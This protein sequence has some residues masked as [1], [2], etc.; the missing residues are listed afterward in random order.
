[1][2]KENFLLLLHFTCLVLISLYGS[3][4]SFIYIIVPLVYYILFKMGTK[5]SIEVLLIL[6]IS[7][8]YGGE[9]NSL[10]QIEGVK[11]SEF[12]ILFYLF[13]TLFKKIVSNKGIRNIKLLD[14]LISIFTISLIINLFTVSDNIAEG[15]KETK[16]L[17]I[18]IFI[19][20][21][22]RS[23]KCEFSI[24]N[25]LDILI[26]SCGIATII[27]LF[28]YHFANPEELGLIAT[29]NRYGLAFYSLFIFTIPYILHKLQYEDRKNKMSIIYFFILLLQIYA[30]LL[31]QNR[32]ILISIVVI[33]LIDFIISIFKNVK[34]YMDLAKKVFVIIG[35]LI[36]S[37]FILKK[38][39]ESNSGI[40]FRFKELLIRNEVAT[41]SIRK[42]TNSYYINQ[43]IS[44][45]FGGYGLGEKMA[46]VK[47]YATVDYG[48][49]WAIDNVFI[50]I[51]YKL[52]ISGL[53]I[54][55]MILI[56]S[57]IKLLKSKS[58]QVY[59][60]IY[61][62]PIFLL[63]VAVVNAQILYNTSI[64]I[65]MWGYYAVVINQ[66]SCKEIL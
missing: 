52:G 45:P 15:I 42:S 28:I 5:E 31:S 37:L 51:G 1:M 26:K 65:F 17:I 33:I 22:V 18:P 38:V 46:L 6:T 60:L 47:Q 39:M 13:M 9:L 43:I 8:P 4:L 36:I 64:S 48:N 10:Y 57:Y 16:I 55:S 32:S 35:I 12:M 34:N 23:I 66:I 7:I 29:G 27:S 59:R 61:I 58:R 14:V 30:I 63:T 21:I 40:L 24:E 11:F 44:N 54:Y 19:Y 49:V 25:I 41:L 50:T 20:F 3:R 53:V 56:N 2:K 62:I